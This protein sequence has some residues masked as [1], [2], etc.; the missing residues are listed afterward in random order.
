MLRSCLIPIVSC[1]CPLEG[2]WLTRRA[3]ALLRNFL[4]ALDQVKIVSLLAQRFLDQPHLISCL[5]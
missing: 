1:D 3:A 4:Q 5:L 2:A